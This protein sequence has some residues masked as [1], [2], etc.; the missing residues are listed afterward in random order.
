MGSSAPSLAERRH[1]PGPSGQG[2]V[3]KTRTKEEANTHDRSPLVS[4]AKIRGTQESRRTITMCGIVGYVG[5]QQ[6][7]PILL[8]GLRRLEYRGYDSAGIAILNG[9]AINV[10][11]SV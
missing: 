1:R 11:R 7:V 5:D 8:N 3:W 10:R 6:A 4:Y 2:N 9:G